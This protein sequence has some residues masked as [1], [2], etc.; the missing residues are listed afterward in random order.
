M[1]MH[2]LRKPADFD[3]KAIRAFSRKYLKSLSTQDDVDELVQTASDSF[4]D[5]MRQSMGIE[6]MSDLPGDELEGKLAEDRDLLAAATTAV[7]REYVQAILASDQPPYIYMEE[8]LY[9]SYSH[10][11]NWFTFKDYDKMRLN[12]GITLVLDPKLGAPM[13][14]MVCETSTCS[15]VTVYSPLPKN[16]VVGAVLELK[17]D[18]EIVAEASIG[19]E[20]VVEYVAKYTENVK[21][22]EVPTEVPLQRIT[23]SGFQ[24]PLLADMLKAGSA[25]V[26]YTLTL[27]QTARNTTSRPISWTV[28]VDSSGDQAQTHQQSY[29]F[30]EE[31]QLGDRTFPVIRWSI[32]EA[33]RNSMVKGE[34]NG[35]GANLP[36][37]DVTFRGKTVHLIKD[38]KDSN[39]PEELESVSKEALLHKWGDAGGPYVLDLAHPWTPVERAETSATRP[40]PP[41]GEAPLPAGWR[42]M[43]AP[44]G[45]PYFVSPENKTSWTRP[46]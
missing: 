17:K 45:R 13:Q 1:P 39:T 26:T 46:S 20:D 8:Q 23:K 9:L 43:K 30:F 33:Q 7:R 40:P 16:D 6:R 22:E 41:T 5:K 44:D 19:Q 27:R 18:E 14:P 28:H 34:Q 32:N 36:W 2:D 11:H 31:L 35:A 21:G 4:W 25:G 10:K 37:H 12:G 3:M 42:E 38:S 24:A 29:V 15:E